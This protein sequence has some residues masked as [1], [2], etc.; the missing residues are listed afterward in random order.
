LDKLRVAR[1]CRHP[2]HDYTIGLEQKEKRD[3]GYRLHRV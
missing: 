1:Y 2:R 3:A